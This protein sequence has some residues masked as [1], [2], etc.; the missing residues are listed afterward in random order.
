MNDMK[1]TGEK[2]G[3]Q[4]DHDEQAYELKKLQRSLAERIRETE[5]RARLHQE[6]E[7]V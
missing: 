2:S 3:S 7:T 4:R 5:R 6:G 1:D